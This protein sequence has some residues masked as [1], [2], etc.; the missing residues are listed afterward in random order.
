MANNSL[1]ALWSLI[2]AQQGLGAL[3][4]AHDQA[5]GRFGENY[6]DPFT[7]AYAGAPQMVADAYGLGGTA[8]TDRAQT[9]FR[10]SPGYQFAFDQGLQALDRSAASRGMLNSGNQQQDLMKFG[11]GL[12]DQEYQN[13]LKGLGG[14]ADAGFGAAQGQT[15]RQ[16]TLAGLDMRSGEGAANIWGNVGRSLAD[17]Y[18][19][20]PQQQSGL[21]SAIAGGLNLGGALL[22]GLSSGGF[23][24][25]AALGMKYWKN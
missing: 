21:S 20:Q 25:L 2:G 12:A 11:Q 6:F 22:G 4:T 9:A 16:G 17:L 1:S 14:I 24:P 3:N 18:Q 10:T 19:P 8:G 13:W 7:R 5:V 15:G 23:K